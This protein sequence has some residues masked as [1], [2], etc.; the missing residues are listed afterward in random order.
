MDR[1]ECEH[2]SFCLGRM[3]GKFVPMSGIESFQPAVKTA[4]YLD[5]LADVNC[6]GQ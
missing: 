4:G 2:Q 1:K 6:D 5:A 3:K